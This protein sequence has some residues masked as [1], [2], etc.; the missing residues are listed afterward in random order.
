MLLCAI[1]YYLFFLSG[2]SCRFGWI[3]SSE[4][5]M[6]CNVFNHNCPCKRV[7]F[8]RNTNPF[9]YLIHLKIQITSPIIFR[10]IGTSVICAM[11]E[12]GA[13]S[14]SQVRYFFRW[15][16]SPIFRRR[17]WEERERDDWRYLAPFSTITCSVINS[18]YLRATLTVSIC[19]WCCH[20]V[21]SSSSIVFSD[22]LY[23]RWDWETYRWI[24]YRRVTEKG[25]VC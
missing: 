4:F 9:V 2:H 11:G 20:E 12:E 14:R 19:A 15:F 23:C 17:S 24:F 25:T 22:Y 1:F 18:E 16:S 21:Y 6:R 3:L 5:S 8:K 7:A 13:R 10:T